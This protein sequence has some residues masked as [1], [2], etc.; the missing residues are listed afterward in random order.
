MAP[1]VRPTQVTPGGAL[2]GV[3]FGSILRAILEFALPK[4]GF[5]V[6][7]YGSYSYDYGPGQVLVNLP[8]DM[9]CRGCI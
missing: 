8:D 7:P 6:I 4:D 2:A 3:L 9:P 5:L 1:Y